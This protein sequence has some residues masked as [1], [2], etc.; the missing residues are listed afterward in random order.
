MLLTDFVMLT[1]ISDEMSM[2]LRLL[3]SA[4]SFLL[5]VIV[6]MYIIRHFWRRCFSLCVCQGSFIFATVFIGFCCI[7]TKGPLSLDCDSSRLFRDTKL[8][9][10]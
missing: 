5:L 9:Q 2:G 10:V 1:D 3:A 7:M 4:A 8:R 6:L